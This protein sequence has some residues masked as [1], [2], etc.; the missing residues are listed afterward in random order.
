[1]LFESKEQFIQVVK[2]FK[3]D[4]GL[5]QNIEKLNHYLQA[6]FSLQ[7]QY[8]TTRM[9]RTSIYL[10]FPGNTEEALNFYK[11]IFK[12]NFAGN[13]IQRFGDAPASAEHPPLSDADKKL[14]LHAELPI[15]GGTLL[16]A[17][18]A[19]ASMGFTL[20]PGNNMHI[21]L[22]PDSREEAK[23]L[24]DGLSAGG[25]ITMPLQDMF[26][27]AYYGSFTDKYGINWMVK[28][29]ESISNRQFAISNWQSPLINTEGFV[30][31]GTLLLIVC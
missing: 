1:M 23:R 18:D 14:V 11:S 21:S 24:F 25:N 5:K 27:G 22:E 8:K 15:T 7:K 10:N 26:W 3:A 30:L 29:Y 20:T 9:A 4:E 16:M 17:T 31:I 13:G 19:P 6:K 2:T 28:P 12:T